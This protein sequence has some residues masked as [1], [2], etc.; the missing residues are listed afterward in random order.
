MV[1]IA[2][3]LGVIALAL[4]AIVGVLPLGLNLQRENRDETIINQEGLYFLEAIRSGGVGYDLTNAVYELGVMT[5]NVTTGDVSTNYIQF[6][7]GFPATGSNIIGHLSTPKGLIYVPN[8][9]PI[10]KNLAK[11]RAQSGTATEI[12]GNNNDLAFTYLLAVEVQ[13]LP[14]LNPNPGYN[15]NDLRQNLYEVRLTCHWPLLPGD[16]VG[17][18]RKVFRTHVS[19]KLQRS[20]GYFYFNPLSY[21]NAP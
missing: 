15:A 21:T 19:G 14:G 11:V 3:A 20:G 7:G 16:R 2:I 12:A 8:G 13:P 4:V 6:N 1:E 18:N 10:E 17:R 9:E 5:T